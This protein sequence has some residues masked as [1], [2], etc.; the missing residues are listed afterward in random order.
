MGIPKPGHAVRGSR[1]GRPIMAL[2]DLLGRR[3]LA[4]IIWEL[5]DA[6]LTFRELR[7][8]CDD[9]SPTVLNQRLRELREARIVEIATD[10]GYT[11]TQAGQD[12]LK[13]MMPLLTW[14]TNWEKELGE[15]AS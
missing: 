4:R 6:R 15:P 10:G 2:L 8:R 7:G 11:L 5:N 12:L 13:A 14:S 9:M 1:T 3:W